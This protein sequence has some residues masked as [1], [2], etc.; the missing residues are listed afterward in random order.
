MDLEIEQ[1]V[2]Q[3][4]ELAFIDFVLDRIVFHRDLVE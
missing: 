2:L 1:A 4:P 3:S